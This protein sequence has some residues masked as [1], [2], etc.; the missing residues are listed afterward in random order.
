M[1]AQQF[2][3]GFHRFLKERT[4]LRDLKVA[5]YLHPYLTVGTSTRQI[6]TVGTLNFPILKAGTLNLRI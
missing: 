4:S 6:W 5:T 1:A 3:D 2:P